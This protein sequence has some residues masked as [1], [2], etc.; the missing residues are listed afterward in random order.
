MRGAGDR[1]HGH[2]VVPGGPPAALRDAGRPAHL[3]A[4]PPALHRGPAGPRR[5]RRGQHR[6]RVTGRARGGG[7]RRPVRPRPGDPQHPAAHRDR[8]QAGL[9]LG[10]AAHLEG[11]QRQRQERAGHGARVQAGADRGLPPDDRPRLPGVPAGR[12]HRAH[13]VGHAL[14][15][16]RAL[17]VRR[18]PEPQRARLGTGPV[19]RAGPADREHRRRALVR[20]RHPSPHPAGGLAGDAGGHGLVLAQAVRVLRPQPGARRPAGPSAHQ[21]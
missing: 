6:V 12:G 19:D 2:L 1:D 20:V 13:A 8:G 18:L 15:R 17:A 4:V 7:R 14:P 3:R 10:R 21:G 5:G 11:R 16:R 9:R